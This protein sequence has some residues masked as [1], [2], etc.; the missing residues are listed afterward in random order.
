MGGN[1]TMYNPWNS[2]WAKSRLHSGRTS[3]KG[4]FIAL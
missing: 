1:K 3:S 2:K 4:D